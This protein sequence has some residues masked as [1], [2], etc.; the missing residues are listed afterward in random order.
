MLFIE[1]VVLV[2]TLWHSSIESAVTRRDPPS[3]L[4]RFHRSTQSYFGHQDFLK[5]SNCVEYVRVSLLEL[6]GQAHEWK[7]IRICLF[8]V[9]EV[10]VGHCWRR[11]RPLAAPAWCWLFRVRRW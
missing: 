9:S 2:K 4:D 11:Q 5:E 1:D 8:V 3:D 10:S 6:G 7:G